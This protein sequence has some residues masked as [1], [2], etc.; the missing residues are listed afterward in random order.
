M[1]IG[2]GLVGESVIES[3]G[4]RFGWVDEVVGGLGL[5]V[6]GVLL[7]C[8]RFTMSE[9]MLVGSLYRRRTAM[10]V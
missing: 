4:M 10:S 3:V 8:R 7:G 6:S 9:V 5:W 2:L 1:A